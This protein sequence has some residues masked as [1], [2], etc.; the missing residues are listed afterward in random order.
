MMTSAVPI[1]MMSFLLFF[2]SLQD[3]PPC[4][5]GRPLRSSSPIILLGLCLVTGLSGAQS[6]LYWRRQPVEYKCLGC[7]PSGVLWH[8]KWIWWHTPLLIWDIWWRYVCVWIWHRWIWGWRCP[9]RYVRSQL[10]SMTFHFF[11]L[12]RWSNRSYLMLLTNGRA[13]SLCWPVTRVGLLFHIFGQ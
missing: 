10:D 13:R 8:P 2:R 4:R 7:P 3:M 9:C 6:V 12:V 1:L 5:I 11:R